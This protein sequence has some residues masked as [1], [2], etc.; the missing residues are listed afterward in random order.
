LNLGGDSNATQIFQIDYHAGRDLLVAVGN[1]SDQV[2]S[3]PANM[4]T[5]TPFIA[6]YEG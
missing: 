6:M 2:F 1:T 4:V 5:P 3:G